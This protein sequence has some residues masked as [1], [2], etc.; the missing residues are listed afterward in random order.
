MKT[1]IIFLFS[2]LFIVLYPISAQ[3][4]ADTARVEV[5]DEITVIGERTGLINMRSALIQS[6]TI[7]RDE[8]CKA[9]CCN[10]AESFET[11]PSVDVSYSDAATG[12]KQIK[13]LGLA[14]TYVQ[15]LHENVPTLRGIS[16]PYGLSY[17]PG[18][19][20]EAIQVSKG[21]SSVANG[22]EAI[23]GQI[24]V[25]YL[26]P[27]NS[28]KIGVNLFA[29][30]AGRF[31]GNINTGF[32]VNKKISTELL[33]HASNE[34]FEI[35]HNKDGFLDQA[36]TQQYNILNRW[37]Y[38]TDNYM[39][40][41]MLRYVY[42]NRD[43]GQRNTINNPYKIGINTNRGEFYWKN[44]YMPDTEPEQSI[45]LILS[46]SYHR[47]NSFFGHNKYDAV[48]G[49]LYANLIYR[50]EFE[51]THKLTVGASANVDNY[52]EMLKMPDIEHFKNTEITPGIFAEYTFHW[53]KKLM[54]LAG[55]RA[56]HSNLYGFFFTP[57]I[58]AKFNFTPDIYLRASAGKGYRSPNI[59]AENSFYLASSR[60]FNIASGLK[61]ENAWNFGV[62]GA[63]HIPVFGRELTLQ[64]EWYYTKFLQQTVVDL[65]SD[66]HE[67]NIGNL[68]GKSYANSIQIELSYEI[69]RGWTL[70]AAHRITDTK[71]TING[72]LREKPLTNRYKS[73][74]TTSYKTKLNKWQF[75]FTA[76]LNGGGRLP[77]PDVENPLWKKTFAPYPIFNAQITKNFKTWSIYLG[78]ENLANFTQKNP[79][80]DA[81]NPF[82]GNFDSAMIW[83]PI[84]GRKIY[85]GFRWG[86][87]RD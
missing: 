16:A 81:E 70:T 43:G 59:L 51:E 19:W 47:Q 71:T 28:D 12:A 80:I 10:L 31:E 49:N 75:D 37:D 35:D 46:G 30:E 87:S 85:V 3:V 72:V 61:Q 50:V 60:K 4:I 52:N 18:P 2:I 38:K 34:L 11:N 44:G 55:V 7:T 74:L 42:E 57:R 17:T 23:T 24:N 62:S 5:L 64:A 21:T 67:V 78:A 86:L 13:L 65:D 25:E 20:M 39:S 22:Y 79:I 73:L 36:K 83:G 82:G 68:H 63:A 1:K 56:D 48:Q 53:K 54:L 33:L 66:P 9:A 14:G 6:Q 27:E 15:M 8:L 45:A 40:R 69:L 29:S 76:Q 32:I 58:H 26:K 77:D 41:L 84:H